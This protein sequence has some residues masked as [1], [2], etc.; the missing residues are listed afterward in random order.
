MRRRLP[1]L[2]ALLL[3]AALATAC[4]ESDADITAKI[5]SEISTDRSITSASHIDV[6]TQKKV[7]TLSGT[8][9]NTIAKERAVALARGTAE[10]RRVVDNISVVAPAAVVPPKTSASAVPAAGAPDDAA[11][12]ATIQT[13]L[14]QD[15]RVSGAKI[16]VET[17]LGI[18]TLSGTVSNE[19]IKQDATQIAQDTAGVQRVENQLTVRGS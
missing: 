1:G 19:Q 16:S 7:V 2:L 17:R 3:S 15:Q 12:T 14:G 9:E 8:A 13:K 10:V 6:S 11:I 18:V 4:E 5:T